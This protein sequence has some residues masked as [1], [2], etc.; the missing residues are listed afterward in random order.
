MAASGTLRVGV[1]GC[2]LMGRTR[3]AALGP[4]VLVAATDLDPRLSAALVAE[5]GEGEAVGDA[6]AVLAHRP[7]VVIVS[8]A[9]DQLAELTC[10]ALAAGAH[11]LVE[12]PAGISGADV[13]RISK[14]AAEADRVV[15][16]GFNHRFHP[17]TARAI[18]EARSG[19]FGEVMF[20]RARYG[21]GGRLGYEQE[22]R[23]KPEISGGGELVDQGMHLLDLSYAILGDVPLHSALLRNQFWSA[24]V[25]D[26]AALLL[27][28]P[29][30]RSAPWA[31]LHVTWT[32]WKTLFSL[33]I[34]CRTG[35]LQ[36]DGLARSYGPQVLHIYTMGPEMGPPAVE[37]I[38]FPAE[39]VSWLHEWQQLRDAVASGDR[40]YPLTGDLAS[41]RYA[42]QQVEKA[43]A[44]EQ[45][46]QAESLRT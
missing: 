37:R 3:T 27:G 28:V 21:H 24:P 18:A 32:E 7:D 40:D 16:V 45:T 8:T 5:R 33:E 46:A 38:E 34:M 39:D 12:K 44:D 22:W 13:E 30:D 41:A 26:N 29:H 11:V 10:Q 42:W 15:K 23:L 17:G 4:D 36:V 1:I 9:H 31:Q 43:Y 6:D 2:G 14:A 25:E 35:K 19:K 20:V